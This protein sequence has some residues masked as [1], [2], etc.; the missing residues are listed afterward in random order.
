MNKK[1]FY[2][3]YGVP[4]SG[5]STY[6]EKELKTKYKNL[7]H[8]E[9]DM[10]F[11]NKN[12]VYQFNPKK[13]G[14][15]H[16]WCHLQHFEADMFFYNKNGVY[17]FNP[18]K[19]GLAHMWCQTKFIEAMKNGF[20]VCVSN[21]SLTPKERE[22]YFTQATAHDYEIHVHYCTGGFQNVHGVPEEKVEKMKNKLIPITE[23]EISE[24]KIHFDN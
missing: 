14:L 6:V 17:Q 16:M 7:Q 24:F 13:L 22:V 21:T 5:K 10:F 20:P 18:K 9:A 23:K 19:L 4:G 11:Y 8:F 3:V 1:I 2:L 15:A 12:G